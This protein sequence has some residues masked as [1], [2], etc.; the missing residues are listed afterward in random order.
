MQEIAWGYRVGKTTTRNAI[1]ETCEVLWEV[2]KVSQLPTPTRIDFENISSDY[3]NRWNIPNCIGAVDGKRINIQSRKKSGTEF[4]NYKKCFSIVLMACCNANMRFKMVDI[5]AACANHDSAV[6][7]QSGLGQA[8]LSGQLDIPPPKTLPYTNNVMPHFFVADAAFSL[9][10]NI[11]LPFSG[12]NLGEKK[13][14]FNYRVS[15]A[16][17]TIESS[18]GILSQRWQILKKPIVASVEVCDLI[19]Q[20][21]VVLH[22]YLQ[23]REVD[24]PISERRYCP[25]GY[26]D[27]VD[28]EGNLQL[29]SDKFYF[30][31]KISISFCTI[32]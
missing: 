28:L 10:I 5:G 8:L 3:V 9:H 32:L 12:S 15:R 2:L 18:F 7:K 24:I 30:S 19:V 11:I 16:R 29:L 14:I 20:A 23:N 22:N 21:T 1:V 6:F 4:F 13:N 31:H 27:F 25:M 26:A 17:R